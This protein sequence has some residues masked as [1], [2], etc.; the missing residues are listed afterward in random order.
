MTPPA[1][2]STAAPSH[3]TPDWP[4]LWKGHWIWVADP[5]TSQGNPISPDRRERPPA[6]ALFRKPLILDRVP[7]RFDARLT[8]DS[9][10]RLRVNGRII[11]RGPVRGQPRRLSFDTYDIAPYLQTGANVIALEVRY[12]GRANSLWMPAVGNATLG[13]SGVAVF[14]GHYT[15]A[16]GAQVWVT[17]DDSWAAQLC[18]GMRDDAHDPDA[19]LVG[20]GVAAES[21]DARGRA[22]DWAQLGFD[23]SS[24]PR[25]LKITPIHMGGPGRSR[26]PSDP[27]GALLPHGLA[28]MSC[29]VIAPRSVTVQAAQGAIDTALAAPAARVEASVLQAQ[30]LSNQSCALPAAT[31]DKGEHHRVIVDMGRMVAGYVAFTIAAEQGARLDISYLE[32]PIRE[33]AHFGAHGGTRYVARGTQDHFETFDRQGFRYVVLISDTAFTLQDLHCIEALYPWRGAHDF[34][35]SDTGLDRLYA[36]SKRTVAL[37]S[38]DCFIDCPSREQRAWAGDSVVHVLTHLACN[39]DIA[40]CWRNLELAASPRS[41]GILPMSV[42]G[43][44]EFGE[45]FTIPDWSLHWLHALFETYLHSGDVARTRALMGPAEGILRWYLPF[46]DDSGLLTD[47]TEWNLVDW[48]AIDTTATSA[49]LNGLWARGL[50]EFAQMARDLGDLGRATWAQDLYAGVQRGFEGFWDAARG[51][52]VDRLVDGVSQ[53]ATNQI[54]TAL[55]LVAGLVPPDRQPRAAEAM[56]RNL[57]ERSWLFKRPEDPADDT[58]ARFRSVITSR[59]TPDWDV[60]RDVVRAQPF[61]SYVVHDALAVAGRSDLL[62]AQLRRWD[63]LIAQGYDSFNE[64]WTGNSHAHGWSSTPARDLV[65]QVLGVRPAQAGFT[66]ARIAPCLG[67]LT[68]LRAS[69]PTPQGPISMHLE[70]GTLRIDSPVP[71]DLVPPA[72]GWGTLEVI[73][74]QALSA[75]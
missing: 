7:D 10:Y 42:A 47:V 69:V 64:I 46:L 38:W 19:S 41:D 62:P 25:A 35:S 57:V 66:R 71:V 26:P 34:V 27:Y 65:G 28:P 8:A 9:R 70:G 52:Y 44:V 11:G 50:R 12:Y 30:T 75:P 49:A 23:D 33:A 21:F 15:D 51:L 68:H 31:L 39:D 56:T 55:A 2:P 43:D 72:Q 24:W 16:S 45:G 17:S 1:S 63:S 36:A 5:G 20:G 14:E 61:M 32:A 74:P 13:R 4:R 67:D 73:C 58:G 40:L 22:G 37:N 6:L 3:H 60:S 54:S 59:F 18:A 53:P 48:S 29:E